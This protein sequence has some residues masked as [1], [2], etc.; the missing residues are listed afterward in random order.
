MFQQ[1]LDKIKIKSVQLMQLLLVLHCHSLEEKLGAVVDVF[2][3][4]CGD[5]IVAMVITLE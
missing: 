5:E 3:D 2:L 1:R 4:E